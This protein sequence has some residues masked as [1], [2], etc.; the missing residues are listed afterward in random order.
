M[1]LDKQTAIIFGGTG[2]L[3][4]SIAETISKHG[5]NVILQYHRRSDVADE[6]VNGIIRNGGTADSF[7][8][9]TSDHEV[10]EKAVQQI[11]NRYG[12]IHIAINS[13]AQHL[14]PKPVVD[15]VWQDWDVHINAIKGHF[16]ICSSV[17][18]YMRQQ[19]YG[20]I[21]FISGGLSYR[22][23][24]GCSAYSAIKA[25]LNAFCKALALEEGE[26]NI[27]V[28]IIAPGQVVT[29]TPQE[30]ND[31]LLEHDIFS[32]KSVSENPLKRF[33]SPDDVAEAALYFVSPAA[34]GIT[35]Q[36]LFVAGGEI[37]P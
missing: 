30:E 20:R 19:K 8:A 2:L 3:G 28:N 33:A 11:A 31:N 25:G 22:Y 29:V 1:L 37:M 15:M 6:I 10:I 17:L 5:V 18:P 24:K 26:R 23:V 36:T 34:S 7:Q 35:G 13:V 27:T 32:K 14:T 16:F 9:D 21:I 12:G 4:R